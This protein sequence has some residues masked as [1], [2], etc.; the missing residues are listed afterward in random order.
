MDKETKKLIE[1]RNKLIN[2]VAWRR[3]KLE[4]EGI[5]GIADRSD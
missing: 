2:E 1:K 3:I 5:K 4:K